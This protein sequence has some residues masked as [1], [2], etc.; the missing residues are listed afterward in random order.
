MAALPT[1]AER[2]LP[3]KRGRV[4]YFCCVIRDDRTKGRKERPTPALA[5]QPKEEG[6][7]A[8]GS[9]KNR[10][11]CGSPEVRCSVI[12]YAGW[13]GGGGGEE[14]PWRW[15]TWMVARLVL[16]VGKQPVG[17]STKNTAAPPPS[18]PCLSC[19]VMDVNLDIEI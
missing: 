5:I 18:P 11:S 17:V 8:C 19:R 15:F 2:G 1:G 3:R 12:E 7:V 14:A 10:A 13:V 9:K 16:G 6:D 4:K